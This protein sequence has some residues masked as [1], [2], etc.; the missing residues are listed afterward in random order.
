MALLFLFC[1]IPAILL[2][3]LHGP[4][5]EVM[6]KTPRK[7][8]YQTRDERRFVSYLVA[9]C[10]FAAF[11]VFAIGWVATASAF[12]P[13]GQQWYRQMIVYSKVDPGSRVTASLDEGLRKFWLVQ[14]VISCQMALCI[15]SQSATML[16]RGQR[17]L[18]WHSCFMVAVFL[19]LGIHAATMFIRAY[20]RGGLMDYLD[21]D[22]IVW[23]LMVAL[24]VLGL[25]VGD[26]INSLDDKLYRRYLQFLRLEFETR[27]GMHSPR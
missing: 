21:L 20:N 4:A 18:R 25:L 5:P 15:L 14:D 9:R 10:S 17:G 16:E 23:A 12:K 6:K 27:L 3:I 26:Q 7:N 1:H 8:I 19:V 24:P 22:W 2:A 13:R 11:S